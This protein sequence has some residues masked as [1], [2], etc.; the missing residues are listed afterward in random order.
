MKVFAGLM[1]LSS[2]PIWAQP[3]PAEPIAQRP[4]VPQMPVTVKG[5]AGSQ[6][7]PTSEAPAEAAKP[8]T[9]QGTLTFVPLPQ[10]KSIEAYEGVEF[11]LDGLPVGPTDQVSRD[12]LVAL[13]DKKV[14]LVCTV[15]MPSL[16]RPDESYPMD[17]DGEPMPRPLKC[18]VSAIKLL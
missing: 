11:R 18:A 9:L 2:T 8:Q 3:G 12:A 14:E 17:A 7:A 10:T 15:E 1:L 5:P 16:P 6:G 4:I 13:K